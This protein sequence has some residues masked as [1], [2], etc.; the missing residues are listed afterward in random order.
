MK[1]LVSV[2]C[3]LFLAANPVCAQSNA[4]LTP[5][6]RMVQQSSKKKNQGRQVDVSKKV[7]QAKKQDKKARRAKP[8]KHKKNKG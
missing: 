3:L 4:N 2:L 1:Y 7:K 8:P 6:Q 5:E